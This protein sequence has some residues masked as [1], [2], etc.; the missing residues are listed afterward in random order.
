MCGSALGSLANG[1]LNILYS[2]FRSLIMFN[3]F[4]ALFVNGNDNQMDIFNTQLAVITRAILL[5]RRA[6][7]SDAGFKII[8]EPT[9]QQFN[10]R[11]EDDVAGWDVTFDLM[12]VQDMSIC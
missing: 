8:G 1:A 10:H 3:K 4:W 7:A 6:A 9:M 5:L 12:V 2:P 11:F